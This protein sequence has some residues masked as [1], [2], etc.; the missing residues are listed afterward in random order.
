[1]QVATR[2]DNG[3]TAIEAAGR[4]V[5][6]AVVGAALGV[7][8][9]AAT[10][11]TGVGGIIVAGAAA[12]A[13][14]GIQFGASFSTDGNRFTTSHNTRPD[15][16]SKDNNKHRLSFTGGGHS[17][18][19]ETATETT[20][21][22]GNTNARD[23]EF[24]FALSAEFAVA[25][26]G[27][28]IG[29]KFEMEQEIGG[30]DTG[31]I[32]ETAEATQTHSFELSDSHLGDV[33]E[34]ELYTDPVYQTT[35][36]RTVA[37]QSRCPWEVGTAP[38]T[39]FSLEL[40]DGLKKLT[41][42]SKGADTVE[43]PLVLKNFSPTKE[44]LE[45]FL[46]V[47]PS[48]N[49][50]DADAEGGGDLWFLTNGGVDGLNNGFVTPPISYGTYTKTFWAERPGLRKNTPSIYRDIDIVAYQ[51]CDWNNGYPG[52]GQFNSPETFESDIETWASQ[53]SDQSDTVTV[54]I[55]FEEDVLQT[56]GLRRRSVEQKS[57]AIGAG[58]TF[59]P[60]AVVAIIQGV[61]IV[62]LCALFL[63]GRK[64]SR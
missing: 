24:K 39:L 23:L 29:A 20:S 48:T 2:K 60:F 56:D 46:Y 30:T 5:V 62:A 26:V 40:A 10:F 7:A 36:F 37:G 28:G 14:A 61:A 49:T 58:T 63:V 18:T 35:V 16:V 27:F 54:T 32:E 59:S 52:N 4:D 64:R 13:V 19:Y 47:P 43:F 53:R 41:M 1:M 38:R 3:E 33:F 21:S 9:V 11:A 17:Y 55:N 44:D 31:E 25:F 51:N 15:A 6:S 22:Q 50:F 42:F 57:V 8:G 45:V 12:G 34:I